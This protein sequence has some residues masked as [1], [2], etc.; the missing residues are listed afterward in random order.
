MN[1]HVVY[2]IQKVELFN[3]VEQAILDVVKKLHYAIY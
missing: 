1:W 3:N 2:I